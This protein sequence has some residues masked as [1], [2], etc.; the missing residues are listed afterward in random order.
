[1][2]NLKRK[3]RKQLHHQNTSVSYLRA[4]LLFCLHSSTSGHW[5]TVTHRT[6]ES[7]QSQ[8]HSRAVLSTTSDS[9]WG[10]GGTALDRSSVTPHPV[11]TSQ[12]NFHCPKLKFL[13]SH[14]QV[15]T[16][17][18]STF[19]LVRLPLHGGSQEPTPT[20]NSRVSAACQ[21]CGHLRQKILT[22]GTKTLNMHSEME[23]K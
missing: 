16:K 14:I 2:N 19:S 6:P 12:A 21:S 7:F 9:S 11:D 18:K 20:S 4:K 22:V 3:L 5:W 17:S 8:E 10:A 1:M 15:Q 23:S 13:L